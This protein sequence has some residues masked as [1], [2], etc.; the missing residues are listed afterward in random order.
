M[1]ALV[2]S[3][4]GV[5]GLFQLGI[6]RSLLENDLELDYD[7]YFGVS[8]G[9]LN[10]SLLATAPL[11]ESLPRLERI[12]FEQVTGN[13]SIWRHHLWHYIL[14]GILVILVFTIAAFM[15]FILSAPK[16][17]TIIFGLLALASLYIPFYSLNNTHSIYTTG[18]LKKLIEDNFHVSA[19]RS[20][21]KK[22][23]IGAVSFNTGKYH[24]A[25]HDDDNLSD[26]ILASSAFPI[27]FPAIQIGDEYWT[28]GGIVDI[29]PLSD[30]IKS[31][32]TQ[33]D[34]ILTSPHQTEHYEGLPGLPKQI[35]RNLDI[36]SSEILRND[37]IYRVSLS[38]VE[39]RVFKPE[40]A[41][42]SNSLDFNPDKT[43]Y[44]YEEGKRIG[45]KILDR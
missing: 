39:V 5:K 1:R 8:V 9:A 28:D 6:L 15:S 26:W 25:S 11:K 20:A 19:V 30:A 22:L 16:W 17:I 4:G 40:F 38:D 14:V 45:K 43:R 32:A 42:I 35:M 37:L 10:S 3:G 2:L 13:R 21:G 36:M 34:V 41:L 7:A 29:A 23:F 31:G 12:W 24:L 33:I 18:P 27:F 44:M